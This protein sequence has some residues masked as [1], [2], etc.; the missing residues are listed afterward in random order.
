[1]QVSHR[2]VPYDDWASTCKIT[3]QGSW[4][5]DRSSWSP[6]VEMSVGFQQVK[7][8][9]RG[10]RRRDFNDTGVNTRQF[11]EHVKESKSG[12]SGSVVPLIA[13]FFRIV[14]RPQWVLYQYHVDYQPPIESR[15]LR[16]APALSA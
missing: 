5:G 1:M 6:V 4:H 12:S 8:G 3:R 13:N 9:E 11:I 10:G 16:T 2:E 15:R 7:L 14:S